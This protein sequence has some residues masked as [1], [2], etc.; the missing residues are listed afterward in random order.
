MAVWHKTLD[1]FHYQILQIWLDAEGSLN[2][3]S[4]MLGVVKDNK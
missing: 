1:V 3:I 4:N 2:L